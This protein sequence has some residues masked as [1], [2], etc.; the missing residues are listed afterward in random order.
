M[1]AIVVFGLLVGLA[2]A[3]VLW[4]Q[5]SRPRHLA[6]EAEQALWGLSWADRPPPM[7]AGPHARPERSA[8][9]IGLRARR[10]AAVAERRA[11]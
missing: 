2:V 11:A 8:L 5:D 6:R 3:A 1:E 4:G 7:P 9:A 10:E